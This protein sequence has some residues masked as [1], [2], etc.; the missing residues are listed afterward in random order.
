MR[1]K[2]RK[3]LL[4]AAEK[5]K[6]TEQKGNDKKVDPEAKT[7]PTVAI[8]PMELQKTT[9]PL[10]D[11]MRFLTPLKIFAADK[12]E[13]QL[14]AFEVYYR[15]GKV[16][17][18]LQSLKRGYRLCVNLLG[19]SS[20]KYWPV[21]LG[22]FTLYL[23]FI[24]SH[25]EQINQT[26]HTVIVEQLSMLPIFDNV[27]QSNSGD[28]TFDQ[29]PS[30][31]NFGQKHISIESK[32]FVIRLQHLLVHHMI[33]L[34]TK[35]SSIVNGQS[36]SLETA[37]DFIKTALEKILKEIDQL[38]DVNLDSVIK[39]YHLVSK[40]EFGKVDS[41]LV[42]KLRVKFHQ[43]F[44]YASLFMTEKEIENLEKELAATDYLT[45]EVEDSNGNAV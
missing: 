40:H 16:L 43:L 34:Q 37:T 33:E 41:L 31:K 12:I 30:S 27:K 36:S 28:A 11:A 29:L 17:L 18:M 21:L 10:S 4:K 8:D 25:K 39:L 19:A 1:N 45:A 35:R 42:E 6:A 23:N 7:E 24:E 2:Q 3:A 20:S 22:Q 26:I 15:K 9:D 32:S 44:P 38:Q 14:L 5:E 13:T